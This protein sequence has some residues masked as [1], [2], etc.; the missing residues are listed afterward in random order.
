MDHDSHRPLMD[1]LLEQETRVSESQLHE[2]RRNLD[3][4]LARASCRERRMRT[5]TLGMAVVVLLGIPIFIVVRSTCASGWPV[6]HLLDRFPTA[7]AIVFS[8]L[9]A[10][11]LACV[12][13]VIPFLLLYFLQ[14]RRRLQQSQQEQTLAILAELQRQIAELRERMP[15][16]AK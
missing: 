2:Y 14:Y 6:Q 11:Y 3:R 5:V 7:G 10:C 12:V 9:V 13:C 4:E 15:P 1:R 16:S 8:V